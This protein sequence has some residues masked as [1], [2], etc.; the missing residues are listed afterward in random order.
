MRRGFPGWTL[1]VCLLA[2]T[3]LLSAAPEEAASDKLLGGGVQEILDR[4]GIVMILILLGSVVAL[5]L[6]FERAVATRARVLVPKR[7]VRELREKLEAG[8]MTEV[9]R[10]VAE[11]KAPLARI[12]LAGWKR[13]ELGPSAA[14]SAMEAAGGHEVAR[15]E[16]PIRPLSILANIQPLLGLLGTILGMI[17]TF[18]VLHDTTPSER[19]AKLAPGIGQALYTT[20]AGLCAAIPCLL[21]F[22]WLRGRVH[23]V[24]ERWSQVGEEF[25]LALAKEDT[26][27]TAVPVAVTT[28][29]VSAP[30]P[31]ATAEA[32]E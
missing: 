7:W 23:R 28:P 17:G 20:A 12:L 13:R 21:L 26:P 29:T 11:R 3:P 4:G 24:A 6:A 30:Q 16:R 14:E 27:S 2:L 9:G 22:H 8:S 25:L 19:V 18:N 15:L 32:A 5:A 10:M 1:L 31:A